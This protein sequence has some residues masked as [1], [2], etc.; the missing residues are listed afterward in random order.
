MFLYSSVHKY[1]MTT[2]RLRHDYQGLQF[3]GHEYDTTT[4]QGYDKELTCQY[5]GFLV[6]CCSELQQITEQQADDVSWCV[7]KFGGKWSR[8]V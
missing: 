7:I 6:E 3:C 2:I 1:D 4:I 8:T 5:F